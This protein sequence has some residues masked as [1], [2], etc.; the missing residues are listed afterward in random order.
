MA[1]IRFSMAVVAL[2]WMNISVIQLV[3]SDGSGLI[4]M[5]VVPPS[6]ARGGIRN[7]FV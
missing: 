1:S 5:M 2:S 3:Y 6:L 4:S 7:N